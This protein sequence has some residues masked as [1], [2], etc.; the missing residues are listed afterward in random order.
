[1]MKNKT[2][3]LNS[4]EKIINDTLTILQLTEEVPQ[5]RD[6][7]FDAYQAICGRIPAHIREGCLKIAIVGVIKSGKSTFVNSLMGKELVKRGA[8]VVT[9]ITTRIRKGKK[10]QANIYLKS[11]DDINLKLQNALLLFPDEEFDNQRLEAFDIRRKNDR[12]YLKKAYQTLVHDFPGTKAAMRPETLLIKHAIQGFDACK[13]LVQADESVI[14][15][16]SKEFDKHKVYTADPNIAFYIK[17]VCLEVFGKAMDPNI[18]IADCQGADSTDPSQLAQVLTYLES[19]NLIVYCIS[20]RTGLR[21]SDITFLKQ[22]K[23]SGL[24]DNIVFINNCDLTEHE[25]LDD[26]IKIETSIQDT[27]EFLKIHPRI[28]SFS[29]LY[30]FFLKIESRLN[31][32]DLSRLKL[33]Q[34]EKKMIQY[35]DLKTKEFN[36][37]FEQ[38]MDKNRYELLISNHLKHLDI[39]IRQVDQRADIFLDLL[40]SDKLKEETAKKTLNHLHHNASRLESIVANSIQSVVSG[41]KDEIKSNLNDIFIRDENAILNKIQTHIQTASLDVEK[42]KFVTKESGFKQILYLLFQDFKRQLDVYVIESVRPELKKVVYDQEKRIATFFQSLFDSYRIDLLK[43]NEYSQFETKIKPIQLQKDFID[44]I[45]I[46]KIKKILGLKLPAK[47][48][49]AKYTPKIK[50]NVFTDFTLQTMSQILSSLF[51]SKSNFSFSPAL[52]KA[53][54]KIKQENQKIIKDQFEQFH[55]NLRANYFFPLIEAATREFE[56]KI[57]ER[58]SLYHSFKE[59]VEHLLSL[60]HSAKKQEKNK[61]LFIKKRIQRLSKDIASCSKI[62][63]P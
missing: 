30:N 59:E 49:E 61:V 12:Q 4:I 16:T 13:D 39:I 5:M 33:W 8:G 11:W 32:K 2:S 45:D 46:D 20:S 27:F 22:I 29:S 55:M 7:S 15:L 54:V 51:N 40:S 1:M 43:T 47:I 44:S 24:L 37:F 52:K 41:L 10:N 34:Q 23:N 31:K 26:L 6:H 53:V 35:S 50:T 57:K 17:D 48:F 38:A 63:Q 58:F 25:N 19:S 18:E 28:F 21:Q 60:K 36:D 9:S 56:E 42:Y 14:C 3:P 62:S